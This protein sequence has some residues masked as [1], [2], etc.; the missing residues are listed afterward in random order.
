MII[1]IISFI[2]AE[3]E[4][5][6]VIGIDLGTTFSCVGIFHKGKVDI[7]PN[8]IGHRITPS[9]VSFTEAQTN[10]GDAAIPFLISNPENTIYAVKRLIGRRFHDPEVQSEIGRLPYKVV[11]KNEKVFH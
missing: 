6:T 11:E 5:R 8:E 2:F 4:S 10:A 7:I 3:E 9:V 1:F